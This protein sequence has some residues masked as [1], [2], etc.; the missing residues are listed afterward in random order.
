MIYFQ[1]IEERNRWSAD[2]ATQEETLKSVRGELDGQ[3]SRL[4][5]EHEEKVQDLENR[6]QT[7][8]G[9]KQNSTKAPR[10]NVEIWNWSY[11]AR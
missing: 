1:V 3:I 11:Q 10:S 7:A 5:A 4:R 6:L 8:L 2:L 9:N